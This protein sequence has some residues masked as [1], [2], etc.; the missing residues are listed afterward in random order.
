[1]SRGWLIYTAGTFI[2]VVALMQ[3]WTFKGSEIERIDIRKEIEIN[4]IAISVL[5]RKIDGLN[6][7]LKHRKIVQRVIDCE[8]S[9]RHEG[10][11]GDGGKSYGIAQFQKRT[12]YY[13]A[14][15]ALKSPHPPFFM[16]GQRGDWKDREDQIQLLTWAV[17]NGYG[18]LWSCYK[19]YKQK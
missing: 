2:I 11:W 10:V 8:S 12:F 17:K 6:E 16:A 13:L 14:A 4:S 1:M 3:V 19:Q 5:Q 9:G 18:N 7:E 15:K